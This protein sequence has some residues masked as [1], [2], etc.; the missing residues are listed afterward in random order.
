MKNHHVESDT[1]AGFIYLEV[2]K[3]TL[4]T[5]ACSNIKCHFLF[6]ILSGAAELIYGYKEI[7]MATGTICFL[8]VTEA[9]HLAALGNNDAK[10]LVNYGAQPEYLCEKLSLRSLDAH[11]NSDTITE[12]TQEMNSDLHRFLANFIVNMQTGDQDKEFFDNQQIMLFSLMHLHFTDDELA[13][14]FAPVL[15]LDLCQYASQYVQKHKHKFIIKL[16]YKFNKHNEN[17][18]ER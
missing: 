3:G 17:H 11:L 13:N 6:F 18:V 7:Y 14:L 15:S 1:S 16:I 5:I 9:C 8:A 2:P 12:Q 4:K 10:I